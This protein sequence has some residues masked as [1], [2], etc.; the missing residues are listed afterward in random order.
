MSHCILNNR[1]LIQY[2]VG[3]KSRVDFYLNIPREKEAYKVKKILQR[4]KVQ[5]VDCSHQDQNQQ[6][7]D[8]FTANKVLEEKRANCV[9]LGAVPRAPLLCLFLSYRSFA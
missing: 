7:S 6:Q 8:V 1:L 9:Y 3:Y 5:I 2:I 4:T